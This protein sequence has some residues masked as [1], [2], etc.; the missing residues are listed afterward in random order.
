[1]TTKY[2][3]NDKYGKY[4]L[5]DKK[6]PVIKIEQSGKIHQTKGVKKPYDGC[7]Y[8]YDITQYI[9]PNAECLE[10]REYIKNALSSIEK[11]ITI[12]EVNKGMLKK[13]IKEP[14]LHNNIGKITTLYPTE[15]D[16]LLVQPK[17]ERRKYMV[18]IL[19]ID[20]G[21]K[22]T[23]G[24]SYYDISEWILNNKLNSIEEEKI[25]ELI[26]IDNDIYQL[27]EKPK[28]LSLKK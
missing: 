1:M 14:K 27:V 19:E 12:I 15:N 22:I 11:Y 21:Y 17:K 25:I 23:P 18:D 3:I 28:K 8:Y 2:L 9:N 16:I 24:N 26:C 20:G 7:N 5:I 4:V 13:I 6:T 10:E